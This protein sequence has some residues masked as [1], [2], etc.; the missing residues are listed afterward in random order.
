METKSPTNV[1]LNMIFRESEAS[2]VTVLVNGDNGPVVQVSNI[3][4]L[5]SQSDF[6]IIRALIEPLLLQMHV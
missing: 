4:E 1:S 2:H 3:L 5:C 6:V